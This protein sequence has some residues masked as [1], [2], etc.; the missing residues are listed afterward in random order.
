[1]TNLIAFPDARR[2]REEA[3]E[4]IARLD[5]ELSAEEKAE[6]AQWLRAPGHHKALMEMAQLWSNLDVVSVLAELFPRASRMDRRQTATRR[7]AYAAVAASVVAVCSGVVLLVQKA[8]L[9]G[10][11]SV[12]VAAD[13]QIHATDIGES[14]TVALSDGSV[15]LLNTDSQIEVHFTPQG[16]DIELRRGE[17]H[18]AVAHDSQRPFNVR[19]GHRVVQAVGT[20][21]NVRMR[22]EKNVELTVTEGSVRL[23]NAA[24]SS[25]SGD[26]APLVK[27]NEFALMRADLQSI[28]VLDPREIEARLAWQK[29]MQVFQGETLEVVLEEIGRYSAT[30]FVIA[31]E[32][33][34]GVR[35]GGF[36]RAGDTEG[37]LRALRTNFNIAARRDSDARV[38]LTAV[39]P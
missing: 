11:D 18:F 27:A 30:E 17:V 13:V 26:A 33:L 16:R 19:V 2:A 10:A 39:A 9:P 24:A 1:M 6:L 12:L 3:A 20:A 28:R 35:V 34:R 7:A 14:R 8:S 5:R 36:F 37:L 38:V 31:E 25:E 23:L 15:L 22:S 32:S 21:F 29:G 4:W